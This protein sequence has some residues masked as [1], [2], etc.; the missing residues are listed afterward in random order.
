MRAKWVATLSGLIA[1]ERSCS[2][3]VRDFS[4]RFDLRSRNALTQSDPD[5]LSLKPIDFWRAAGNV[6]TKVWTRSLNAV[7]SN[8]VQFRWKYSTAAGITVSLPTL[9]RWRR[10]RLSPARI[11]AVPVASTLACRWRV[12]RGTFFLGQIA[13]RDAFASLGKISLLFKSSQNALLHIR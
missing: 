1:R 2:R 10:P 13:K 8:G 3:F 6:E 4:V 9:R 11:T 7:R 5:L 12:G